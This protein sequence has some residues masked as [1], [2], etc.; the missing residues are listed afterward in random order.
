[1]SDYIFAWFPIGAR[2]Q[3]GGEG[4]NK[5]TTIHASSLNKNI[6]LVKYIMVSWTI[7]NIL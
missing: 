7:M 5:I 2:P 4:A 3:Y 6:L 1:M